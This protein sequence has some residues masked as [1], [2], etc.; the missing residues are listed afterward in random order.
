M[1]PRTRNT[2]V[3][4]IL[5]VF[6]VGLF[7]YPW[8]IYTF[9]ICNTL[10]PD[11]KAEGAIF[12]T[13][14]SL[15]GVLALLCYAR[16]LIAPS[17]KA[18]HVAAASQGSPIPRYCYAPGLLDPKTQCPQISATAAEVGN[19]PN[20]R[21][22]LLPTLCITRMDGTP[23]YC[24][25]CQCYKPDRTHHCKECNACILR[26]DHHCP[27]ISGCV[28]H[29]N[30]K[31]FYLFVI[32]SAMYAIWSLCSSIPLI[33]NALSKN[34][35]TLDPQWIVLLVL[36]F[37]FGMTLLG[38]AGVHTY[39][40]CM[41][42]TTIEHI[43]RRPYE[44]RVDLDR[45]GHNYEIVTTPHTERL[46]NLGT[47]DNWRSVMGN[48]PWGWFVPWSGG[49]GNGCVFPY[50]NEVYARVI[51]RAKHQRAILNPPA[52]SRTTGV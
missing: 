38:F 15:F 7:V 29:R 46:W 25:V 11:N 35:A 41:N 44:I 6:V 19:A 30:Y 14:A 16:V 40:I 36:G 51:E 32:Y 12:I 50:N 34:D 18:V 52:P 28:G 49:L 21:T 33:V 27:W 39:Y 47:C 5:P 2:V 37:V 1:E 20:E 23:R 31:F 9:R 43:S 8:Y 24:D 42:Q 48:N 22:A 3:G 13:I 26:M 17:G 10:F 4:I 45:T